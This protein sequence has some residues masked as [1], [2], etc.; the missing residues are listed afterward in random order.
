MV[1]I[2]LPY[3][4]TE[5]PVKIPDES[6]MGVIDAE[7]MTMTE[8]ASDEIVRAIDN[9]IGSER[10]EKIVEPG[11]KVTIIADD[12]FF[13][14]EL[15]LSILIGK[16][17]TL[18]IKESEITVILGSTIQCLEP[19]RKFALKEMIK[20]VNIIESNMD[21][22]SFIYVGDTS[23]GTRILLNKVFAEADVR[24]LTGRIS[25][26]PFAGYTGGRDGILPVCGAETIRRSGALILNSESKARKL[27]ENPLHL[28]LEEAAKLAKVNFIV[29]GILNSKGE[30]MRMFAGDLDQSFMGGVKFMDE[31]FCLPAEKAA[32]IVIFSSGGYPWDTTLYLSCGGL[33]SALSVIKDGGVIIWVAESIEGYGNGVFC[34]WMTRFK[35]TDEACVEIKRKFMLGGD[36]AYILMK[37]LERAKIILVSVLP[38][39]YA[40]GIFRLK[41]ARTVNTALNLAFKTLD[42]KAKVLV[43]PHGNTIFPIIK[44]E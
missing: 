4:K 9:P 5:A 35:T 43:I 6:L 30:I 41:T 44:K 7:E 21:G 36:M 13:P 40:T 34:D 18:G 3:G 10:L 19:N 38:D 31:K 12:V 23:R 25:F 17:T 16:L 14:N 37:A 26:H 27:D 2:W 1:E 42:K 32:D 39:Y 24:I 22:D 28:E 33:S 29:N 8:K 11:D 15:V 20:G